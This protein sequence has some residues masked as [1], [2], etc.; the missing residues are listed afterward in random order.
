MSLV[1]LL[2]A[3]P[4]RE[5]PK[6]AFIVLTFVMLAIVMVMDVL[7]VNKLNQAVETYKS[8]IKVEADGSSSTEWEVW[9]ANGNAAKL[10]G[11][12]TA[13]IIHIVFE[14]IGFALVALLPV[15]RNL[16]KKINTRVVIEENENIASIDLSEDEGAEAKRADGK[17]ESA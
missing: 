8:L 4:K 15:I 5:K 1:C 16:M 2:N 7:Y 9:I 13:V 11:A 14:A 12:K 3:F 6:I 10:L 17:R